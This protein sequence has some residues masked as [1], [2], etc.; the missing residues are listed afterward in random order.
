MT[1]TIGMKGRM[2][3][4]PGISRDKLLRAGFPSPADEALN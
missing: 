3:I 1:I 2:I 4:N